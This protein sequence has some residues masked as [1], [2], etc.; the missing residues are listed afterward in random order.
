MSSSASPRRSPVRSS[1]SR[2]SSSAY[3]LR[4]SSIDSLSSARKASTGKVRLLLAAQ[5]FPAQALTSREFCQRS[6]PLCAY[7]TSWRPRT[8]WTPPFTRPPTAIP[9]AEICGVCLLYTLS[10]GTIA[11]QSALA[12]A[13][14][15]AC[16]V[17][18]ATAGVFEPKMISRTQPRKPKNSVFK[19]ARS[20]PP[21][22]QFSA[23]IFL[24]TH[25]AVS[26]GSAHA[27][28]QAEPPK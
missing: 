21:V 24:H 23:V 26:P 10:S 1:T 14:S 2:P 20:E 9:T 16:G 18:T 11:S 3:R 15:H 25:L 4:A 13:D 7:S 17:A 28:S 6:T 27:A 5:A 22:W 19:C 12:S 8:T